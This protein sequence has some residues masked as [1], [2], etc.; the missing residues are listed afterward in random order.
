G[1]GRGGRVAD[2]RRPPGAARVLLL[3]DERDQAR[4]RMLLEPCGALEE[5][6]G[7]GVERRRRR[8]ARRQVTRWRPGPWPHGG[9]R[10]WH[11]GAHPSPPP[12]RRRAGG[13]TP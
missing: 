13:R 11:P 4:E 9:A 10:R 7:R 3:L 5:R 1:I 6:P 8:G 2:P 12:R